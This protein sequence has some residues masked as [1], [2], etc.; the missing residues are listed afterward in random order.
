MSILIEKKPAT[1]SSFRR[2]SSSC[3]AARSTPRACSHCISRVSICTFVLVKQ[4]N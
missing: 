2:R 3:S 1:T 4:V